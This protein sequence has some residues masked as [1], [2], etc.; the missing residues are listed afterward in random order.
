MDEEEFENDISLDET[1]AILNDMRINTS[2]LSDLWKALDK[3]LYCVDV[4][5]TLK[6]LIN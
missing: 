6:T 4:V 3:A 5:K 1:E 2:P